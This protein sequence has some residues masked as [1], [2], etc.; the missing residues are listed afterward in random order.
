MKETHPFLYCD[1]ASTETIYAEVRL[2]THLSLLRSRWHV[3]ALILSHAYLGLDLDPLSHRAV[4]QT[5]VVQ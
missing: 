1:F 4:V 5:W 2:W 3:S